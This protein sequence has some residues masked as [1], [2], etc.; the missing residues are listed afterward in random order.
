MELGRDSR[1]GMVLGMILKDWLCPLHMVRT[2]LKLAWLVDKWFNSEA[3]NKE[4]KGRKKQIRL[5]YIW[6]R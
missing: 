4:T 1:M 5:A 3:L 2:K 6:Q